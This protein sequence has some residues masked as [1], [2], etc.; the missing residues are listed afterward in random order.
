MKRGSPTTRAGIFKSAINFAA[1]ALM[2][3]ARARELSIA[4]TLSPA[5]TAVETAPGI[6]P[7]HISLPDFPSKSIAAVE[8]M[9]RIFS[10]WLP[11][12]IAIANGA[13]FEFS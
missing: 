6:V 7:C 11:S 8:E 1:E 3:N 4:N 5:A 13:V 10:S 2:R 9:T 12:R